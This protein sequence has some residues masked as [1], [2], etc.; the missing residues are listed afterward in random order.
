MHADGSQSIHNKIVA[1][2]SCDSLGLPY[3]RDRTYQCNSTP[4]TDNTQKWKATQWTPLLSIILA[5]YGCSP[6]PPQSKNQSTPLPGFSGV[7]RP[8]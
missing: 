3:M 5:R 7:T 4:Y 6:M 2:K 1:S 8:V